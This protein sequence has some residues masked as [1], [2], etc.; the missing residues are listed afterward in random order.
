MEADRGVLQDEKE[1]LLGHKK[2]L[3]EEVYRLRNMVAS[4]EEN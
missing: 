4:M 2:V 1:K 3:I